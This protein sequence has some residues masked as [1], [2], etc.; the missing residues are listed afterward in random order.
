MYTYEPWFEMAGAFHHTPHDL[1]LVVRRQVK[2][3]GAPIEGDDNVG[4]WELPGLLHEIAQQ[5]HIV[6]ILCDMYTYIHVCI[7]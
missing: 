3:F 5:M 2:V 7:T 6:E 4:A 1:V